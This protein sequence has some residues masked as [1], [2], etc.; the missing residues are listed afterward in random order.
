MP[1]KPKPESLKTR[2]DLTDT[3]WLAYL[4]C[5]PEYKGIDIFMLYRNMVDWCFKK[6][7]TPTRLRLINWL[8][9]EAEALPMSAPPPSGSGSPPYKGGVAAAAPDEVVLLPDCSTCKN[10]RFVS[11]VVRPDAEFDWQKTEMKPCPDCNKKHPVCGLH[12]EEG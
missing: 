10:E 1:K 4:R 3:E 8:N 2:P 9:R 11:V 12:D 5:L 7:V 6:G